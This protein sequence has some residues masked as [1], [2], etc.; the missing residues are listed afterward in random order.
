MTTANS[1]TDDD[2]LLAVRYVLNE[3]GAAE[4]AAFEARLGDDSVAQVALVEAVQI[5]ALLQA[6]PTCA[7]VAPRPARAVSAKPVP[8]RQSWQVASL[9]AAALLV[10]VVAVWQSLPSSQFDRTVVLDNV[11]PNESPALAQ[12]WTALD[13]SAIA[14]EDPDDAP[15]DEVLLVDDSGNDTA[16]DVPDWLLSAVMAEAEQGQPDDHD[17]DLEE[18]TQL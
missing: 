10:V 7:E 2:L 5:V 12:A 4:L 1:T 3:C 11:P 15:A 18:E 6:T 8:A 9:V 16:S 14:A 13:P 17:M